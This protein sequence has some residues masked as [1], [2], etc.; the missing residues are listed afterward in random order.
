MLMLTLVA[1]QA[2]TPSPAQAPSTQVATDLARCTI[3]KVKEWSSSKEEAKVIVETALR[4][5]E[6]EREA[7]RTAATAHMQKSAPKDL[8][9]SYRAEGIQQMVAMVEDKVKTLSYEALI[10]ARMAP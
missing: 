5:C 9:G 2:A 8:P 4:S 1:L 6:T 7:V 10:K 3:G